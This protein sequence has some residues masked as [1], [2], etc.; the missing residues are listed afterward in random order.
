MGPADNG[1]SLNGGE[2]VS[3]RN[4]SE[5]LSKCKQ[6][7]KTIS[8][9]SGKSTTPV[10]GFNTSI[11]M[12]V[13]VS[14]SNNIHFGTHFCYR[15]LSMTKKNAEDVTSFAKFPNSVAQCKNSRQAKRVVLKK[16]IKS[17]G[18]NHASPNVSNTSIGS[19]IL[20][21]L[22]YKFRFKMNQDQPKLVIT[23]PPQD[24]SP[25]FSNSKSLHTPPSNEKPSPKR[26]KEIDALEDEEMPSAEDSILEDDDSDME[27]VNKNLKNSLSISLSNSNLET[28]VMNE[29]T[30]SRPSSPII[31]GYIEGEV[32]ARMAKLV[33]RLNF[34]AEVERREKEQF[35]MQLEE[36]NNRL[37]NNEKEMW[38]RIQASEREVANSRKIIEELSRQIGILP[39]PNNQLSLAFP[40]SSSSGA[41]RKDIA[42][43]RNS[44][45][46]AP[47]QERDTSED[48]TIENFDI[49]SDELAEK[50][51]ALPF[52]TVCS[53]LMVIHHPDYSQNVVTDQIYLAV[54]NEL[55][56][57]IESAKKEF[58]DEMIIKINGIEP[59]QGTIVIEC[60][61][62]GTI[63]WLIN[64]TEELNLG[65]TCSYVKRVNYIPAFIIWVVDKNVRFTEIVSFLA[66]DFNTSCWKLV[67]D[68]SEAD[69]RNRNNVN[70]NRPEMQGSRYLFLANQELKII[71]NK[72]I[73]SNWKS[74]DRGIKSLKFQWKARGIKG[75]IQNL[76]GIEESF[77]R[78][79]GKKFLS[80]KTNKF[81]KPISLKDS[82]KKKTLPKDSVPGNSS[83]P[84]RISEDS[85]IKTEKMVDRTQIKGKKNEAKA[86]PNSMRRS[87]EKKSTLNQIEMKLSEDNCMKLTKNVLKL[88]VE[89]TSV[90]AKINTLN[91][92]ETINKKWSPTITELPNRYRFN[93]K[94]HV[95][96]YLKSR[97]YRLRLSYMEL[98]GWVPKPAKGK[99][100]IA[101]I[102]MKFR[103]FEPG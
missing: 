1:N 39:G 83:K 59:K 46:A 53:T 62:V 12:T 26:S 89:A 58:G 52:N 84:H 90:T 98:K 20:I 28:N 9:V 79:N 2:K 80:S 37:E 42:T 41:I 21:N 48:D 30:R 50:V 78:S 75:S 8:P 31:E 38:A 101:T 71:V 97:N 69:K 64:A 27:S 63:G 43:V 3:I 51:M 70:I 25:F 85:V 29:N 81:N 18:K 67:K 86:A 73:T 91:K 94:E 82:R 4:Q 56:E 49:P 19:S 13:A 32:Q 36:A 102:K 65:L 77:K 93:H 45:N 61:N 35:K 34:N 40:M 68:F 24:N 6:T 96:G 72:W 92:N 47:T 103:R 87:K 10:S 57:A 54:Q 14:T 17:Q 11:L 99:G 5:Q 33:Q 100:S 66:N 22:T 76:T 16:T 23:P 15:K 74:T 55:T 88:N 95:E 44:Q 7:P 60:C